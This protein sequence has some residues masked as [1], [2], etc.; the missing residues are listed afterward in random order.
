MTKILLF[1]WIPFLTYS[2]DKPIVNIGGAL[3]Y[4]YLY[5]SWNSD[6]KD[7]GG[8]FIYDIFRI[9][10]EARYKDVYL[11]VEYREYSDSFGGG[12]LKQGWMGYSLSEQEDIQIGLTQV[13]F[14]IQTY[15]S[16]NWFFNLTYYVSLE[17]DHDMGIK[18][19]NIGDKFEYQLAFFKNSELFD[20]GG[21]NEVSSNRYAYDIVGKNKEINQFNGKF[22]YKTGE[23]FKHR[24]GFSAQYGGL[25]NIE[26]KE[27]GDHYALGLHHELSYKRW[28][29]KTELLTVGHNPMNADGQ[30]RDIVRMGAYGFPYDVASDFEM[31]TAAVSY[32]LPVDIGP[33][34]NLKFYNDFGYMDK[35]AQGFKNSAMNVT[36]MLVSAGDV[37][38]YVDYAAGYNHSWFGGDFTNELGQGKPNLGWEARFNINF[39]YYFLT[40]NKSR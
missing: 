33:I 7:I 26:T 5:S 23:E 40:D 34:S 31:Y 24:I 37:F 13:P 27:N 11:N 20:L 18:Y 16:N 14:G 22:I 15:N 12:F 9:N 2:Q 35:R 28:N 19:M 32:D 36:G 39:G 6:Q 1:I 17:D 8:D 25:Y 10:A 21:S 3:R 4:N 29:L 30:S 38:I